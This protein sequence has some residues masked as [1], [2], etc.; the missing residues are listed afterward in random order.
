MPVVDGGGYA[1]GEFGLGELRGDL[2]QL[3]EGGLELVRGL[4]SEPVAEVLAFV[5]DPEAGKGRDVLGDKVPFKGCDLEW[6]SW[7]GER[8]CTFRS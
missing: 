7:R 8:G 3:V 2:V 4:R 1:E 5:L 6:G